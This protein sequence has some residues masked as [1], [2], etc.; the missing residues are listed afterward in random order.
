MRITSL[1]IFPL[2]ISYLVSFG[3]SADDIPD[4]RN[5]R[6][7]F[8]KLTDKVLRADLASFTLA[9]IVEGVSKEPLHR[10]TVADFKN[11]EVHFEDEKTS[12]TI[13]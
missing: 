1:L 3:Q 2:L 12:I 10:F 6:E 5:K 4:Y 8:T 9:G 13:Y 7:G 11:N